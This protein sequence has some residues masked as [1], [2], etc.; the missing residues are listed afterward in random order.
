MNAVFF[1]ELATDTSG[2]TKKKAKESLA[3]T[4]THLVCQEHSTA[5]FMPKTNNKIETD[6]L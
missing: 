2:Y 4:K 5:I 6:L 3:E 1:V